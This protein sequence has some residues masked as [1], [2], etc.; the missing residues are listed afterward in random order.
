MY[1]AVDNPKKTTQFGGVVAAPIVG[2]II[3]DVA[4]FVGIEKS[5]EQLERIIVGVI[6]SL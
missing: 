1:V 6:Q 3:E 5:K 2:Q 4:P